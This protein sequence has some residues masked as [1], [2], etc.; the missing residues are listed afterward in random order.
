MGLGGWGQ[1]TKS[2]RSMRS[3]G[4]AISCGFLRKNAYV[5]IATAIKAYNSM[6][7]LPKE[8]LELILDFKYGMEIH[9]K[10]ERVLASLVRFFDY[11]RYRRFIRT[12]VETLFS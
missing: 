1:S 12:T 7:C 3:N 4:V 5:I 8:L 9:E 6:S 11:V 10:H 2:S